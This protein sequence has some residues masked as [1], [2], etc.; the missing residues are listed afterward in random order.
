MNAKND[1][2]NTSE[3][4]D[5]VAGEDMVDVEFTVSPE[6][7]EKLERLAQQANISISC[8]VNNIISKRL[9]DCR[10]LFAY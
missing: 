8:L 2:K 4:K 7:H 9:E 10:P 3:L 1:V 6:L 5:D